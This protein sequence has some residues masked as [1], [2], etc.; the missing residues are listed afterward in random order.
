MPLGTRHSEISRV[1]ETPRGFVL[2]VDDGG[3]L[4]LE[5]GWFLRRHLEHRMRIEGTRSGFD[6]LRIDR[7]ARL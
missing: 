3:T 6:A 4:L 1:Q 5:G 2:R 7:V